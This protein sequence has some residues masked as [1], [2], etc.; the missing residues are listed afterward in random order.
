MGSFSIGQ[1]ARRADVAASTIRYYERIGLLPP[2]ARVSG[3]RR[4][5]G[6]ILDTLGMIRLAQDA[7]FSLTEIDAL[8]YGFPEQTPPVQRWHAF[9]DQKI[10]EL[11]AEIEQAQMRKAFLQKTRDCTCPT[12][13]DCVKESHPYRRL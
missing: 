12:F 3:K 10:A 7:G 5:D 4:Y 1:I 11:D 8:L 2:A 9:A 13:D 6:T